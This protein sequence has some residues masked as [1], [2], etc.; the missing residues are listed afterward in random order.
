MP[1]PAEVPYPASLKQAANSNEPVEEVI[2]APA[3]IPAEE[4]AA[5]EATEG[6]EG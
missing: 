4:A 6:Q 5:P 3:D 2:D 1:R